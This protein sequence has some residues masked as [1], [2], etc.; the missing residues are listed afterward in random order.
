MCLD[1]NDIK[2]H[3]FG[4]A[5]FKKVMDNN[6]TKSRI[7]NRTGYLTFREYIL[8]MTLKLNFYLIL[9]LYCRVRF[10]L[11]FWLTGRETGEM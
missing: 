1:T 9:L 6:K 11:Q 3:P 4:M 7:K 2:I 8:R 10:W 5:T